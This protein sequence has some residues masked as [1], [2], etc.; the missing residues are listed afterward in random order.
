MSL[1]KS[2]ARLERVLPVSVK[3]MIYIRAL[4]KYN[5]SEYVFATINGEQY[6]TDRFRTRIKRYCRYADVYTTPY[7]LRHYFETEYARNDNCNIL[8]L[9][10]Y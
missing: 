10:K 4:L 2:K 3:V 9:Q 1:R 6:S 8:Y 5:K 7:Q